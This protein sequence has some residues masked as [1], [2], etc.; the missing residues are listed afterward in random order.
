MGLLNTIIENVLKYILRKNI[1]SL[2]LQNM[3]KSPKSVTFVM[4]FLNQV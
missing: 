2:V 1:F 3:A 4:F